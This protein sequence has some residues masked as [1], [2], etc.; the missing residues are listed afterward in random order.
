MKM[1][2]TSFI[3]WNQQ[4]SLTLK[5]SAP[6]GAGAIGIA[7]STKISTFGSGSL[8][9]WAKELKYGRRAGDEKK[10]KKISRCYWRK[11]VK[12]GQKGK[13]HC[14]WRSFLFG[15]ED[16]DLIQMEPTDI[17]TVQS[18]GVG[19]TWG[20]SHCYISYAQRIIMKH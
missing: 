11:I 15:A 19:R 3:K 14:R 7:T 6:S 1:E 9:N 13:N 16:L 12:D 4:T 8:Q 17:S 18:N 5:W 10:L 2:W 20:Q